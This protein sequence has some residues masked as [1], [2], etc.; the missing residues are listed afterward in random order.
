MEKF[1]LIFQ[2]PVPPDQSPEH[3]Q[4]G[5]EKWMAWIDKLRQNDQYVAGDWA[6]SLLLMPKII[7][8]LSG[9]VMIIPTLV[10]AALCR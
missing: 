9:C 3:M 4:K 5:M 2:G 10:M 6:V 7:T 1:M 8:K